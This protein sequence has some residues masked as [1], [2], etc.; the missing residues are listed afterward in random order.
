MNDSYPIKIWSGLLSNGHTQKIENALWEF[1]WLINKVTKEENGIGYVLKGK[2]IKVNDIAKDLKRDYRSVLRHI[3]KLEKQG[4]INLKRCPYGF[5]FTINNSKKFTNG[6]DKNVQSRHDKNI[7]SDKVE[8]V[9]KCHGDMTKMSRRYDKNVQ[10]KE[11]NKDIKDIKYSQNS[12]EYELS[13][14]LY[15]KILENNP[16]HKEPNFNSWSRH[17]DLMI[18][19]DKRNPDKIKEVIDWCQADN[20]WYKNI[21]STAKLRDKYDQLIL[22]MKGNSAKPKKHFKN[23][24]EY[25]DE[26]RK[27]IEDKFYS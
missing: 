22:N 1:I 6:Y 26:E 15:K 10:N 18:R 27:R 13:S 3:K 8:S 21:L 19:L 23:E 7:Q 5:V 12:I 4:Y 24:R 20:F 11:D 25:T 17:I 16:E 14:Y 9:Q 2:P